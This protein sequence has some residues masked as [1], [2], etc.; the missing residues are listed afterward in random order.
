M[1][2]EKGDFAEKRAISFLEDSNFKIIET[3]FYAKKLGEIKESGEHIKE[4]RK[5]ILAEQILFFVML[6]GLPDEEIASKI[7][8]T[9]RQLRRYKTGVS[10]PKA[11]TLYELCRVLNVPLQRMCIL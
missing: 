2:K 1:S 11:T 8:V 4:L 7:G 5:K 9:T 6:S 10:E 3:N